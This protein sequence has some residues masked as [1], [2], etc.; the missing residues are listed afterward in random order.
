MP[1]GRDALR[2]NGKDGEKS[3][4]ICYFGFSALDLIKMGLYDRDY[5]Q[6]NYKDSY[7]YVPQMRIG[8]PLITPIVKRLLI[9]NSLIFIITFIKRPF[10][11]SAVD[12]FAVNPEGWAGLQIWRL[13]TYQFLH[14]YHGFGH[15]FW[16]ML[17]LFFFGPL[18]ERF[19]GSRKFLVFYLVCGAA[20]G[21]LYSLLALVGWL[22]SGYLFG[23][24]GAILGVLAAAALLFPTMRVYIFWG[25]LPVPL[26][27]L[28]GVLA[29]ISTLTL[30]RPSEFANAGGQA[31]HLAGMVAGAA[32]VLS[33]PIRKKLSLNV[34]SKRWQRRMAEEQRV[35]ADVDGILEKVYRSGIGSLS[36]KEKRTL[37]K[38]TRLEQMKRKAGL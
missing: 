13:I 6:E 30:L 10:G 18:L 33:G 3:R 4:A 25:L 16:N 35:Q 29:V 32:Y 9:I 21:V 28:A 34:R 14:D 26:I 37:K 2:H 5:T 19:W 7:Q 24:S 12:L 27:V 15:I 20:G 36:L 23:A 31:A 1:P 11:D 22:P 8:F 17:V 38:A